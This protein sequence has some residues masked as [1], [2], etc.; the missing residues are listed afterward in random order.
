MEFLLGSGYVLQLTAQDVDHKL[1]PCTGMA[2]FDIPRAA[3]VPVPVH[4]SC[5][6]LVASSQPVPVPRWATL[7]VAALLLTLGMRA[8]R[9]PRRA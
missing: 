1:A 5:H 4:L 3:T 9:R 2:T 8:L 6:E 7:M